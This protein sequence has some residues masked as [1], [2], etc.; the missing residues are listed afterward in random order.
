MTDIMADFKDTKFAVVPNEFD[1]YYK[2]IVVLCD[3][4]YWNNNYNELRDW[5]NSND[6][7]VLGMTVNVPDDERLTIFILR[8]S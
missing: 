7:E 5:C 4:A 1:F 3:I 6:C 8:W 2:H